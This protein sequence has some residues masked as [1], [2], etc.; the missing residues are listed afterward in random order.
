MKKRQLI[1]YLLCTL[2]FIGAAFS[3]ISFFVIDIMVLQLKETGLTTLYSCCL[4]PLFSFVYGVLS[5]VLT[6]KIVIP[7]ILYALFC[8]IF[9]IL[10][11]KTGGIYVSNYNVDSMQQF[12]FLQQLKLAL[13]IISSVTAISMIVSSVISIIT[14]IITKFVISNTKIDWERYILYHF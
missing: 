5:Y 12:D 4:F 2:L 6:K 8:A 1:N 14:S 13:A 9:I 7:N 11:V 10:F 3:F